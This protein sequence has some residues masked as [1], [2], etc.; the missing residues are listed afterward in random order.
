[1]SMRELKTGSAARKGL[2]NSGRRFI[3]RLFISCT[4]VKRRKELLGYRLRIGYRA[5][6]V[7]KETA[8]SEKALWIGRDGV[9]PRL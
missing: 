2:E 1:M 7:M 9:M 4:P 3:L 8:V 6:S 5:K